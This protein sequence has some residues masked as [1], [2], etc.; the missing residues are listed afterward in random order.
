MLVKNKKIKSNPSAGSGSSIAIVVSQ[1]NSKITDS[2]LDKCLATLIKA[3]VKKSNIK[4]QKVPGALEIPLA[5]QKLAKTK[6]YK[7]IIA[8]GAVI[9]GDTYHFELV[10]NEC[11]RGCM[12]VMLKYEIPIIFEVLATYNKAQAL[13]RASNNKFNK[14]IEAA[15][16]ALELIEK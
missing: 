2:L 1:F 8:L 7:A 3:G 5:C 11:V 4:I 16:A 13:K 10:A 14:G 9:K 15:N 6:K 12:E